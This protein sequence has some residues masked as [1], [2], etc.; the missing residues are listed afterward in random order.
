MSREELALALLRIAEL[1]LKASKILLDNGLY[2][3]AVFYAQ[4]CCEKAYKAFLVFAE[5]A[6]GGEVLSKSISHY[7]FSKGLQFLIDKAVKELIEEHGMD[8]K[9]FEKVLEPY[10][11]FSQASSLTSFVENLK[12]KIED[13]V[14]STIGELS[15]EKLCEPL[16]KDTEKQIDE[17]IDTIT[18]TLLDVETFLE[19][20]KLG[21]IICKLLKLL[22][23]SEEKLRA[24]LDVVSWSIS[25]PLLLAK[26]ALYVFLIASVFLERFA[27]ASR[28]P[29]EIDP[30]K[31]I[32]YN[33][34]IT[35]I[36]RD[37][38]NYVERT[39]LLRHMY[40]LIRGDI[41]DEELKE[42]LKAH[43]E[44]IKTQIKLHIETGKSSSY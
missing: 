11:E 23:V 10:L 39:E 22:H 43:K 15:A 33:S 16:T 36:A 6:K 4:Q 25:R 12:R 30:S 5:L 44:L 31:D 1:D 38:I 41:T 7:P 35:K 37:F 26:T 3:Q 24:K 42:I 8:E 2:T 40:E 28:Y 21:P 34:M 9:S 17:I 20:I 32:K 19:S 13:L 18:I 29:G 27:V 14:T